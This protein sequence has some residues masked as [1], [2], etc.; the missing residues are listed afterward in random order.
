MICVPPSLRRGWFVRWPRRPPDARVLL[1]PV[2]LAPAIGPKETGGS[3][4]FP[5]YPSDPMPRSQTP[6]VSCLLA[7]AQT[8]LLP[9][10]R[11]IRSALSPVA[12]THSFTTIINFSELNDAAWTLASP[13]LRTPPLSSR[14]SVRLPTGWLTF[15]RVGLECAS[16][17]LGNID[18]FQELSAPFPHPGFISARAAL[19]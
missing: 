15:G 4:E 18:K 16:H 17:P 1:A 12:Q 6:V 11:C 10:Q 7:V 19:C 9:S 8:G 14:P 13:L 3:P 5:G 2:T